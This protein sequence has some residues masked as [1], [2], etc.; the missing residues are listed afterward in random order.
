MAHRDS[1]W[2]AC[3]E[4]REEIIQIAKECL[5]SSEM[6]MMPGV[7][8]VILHRKERHHRPYRR[9]ASVNATRDFGRRRSTISVET[10]R[11]PTIHENVEM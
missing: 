7:Q 6:E 4:V 3:S 10:N 11:I 9:L 8:S 1:S 2:K 5:G